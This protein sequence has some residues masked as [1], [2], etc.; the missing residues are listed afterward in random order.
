M[1]INFTQEYEELRQQFVEKRQ[2]RDE[3]KKVIDQAKKQNA[4][5]VKKKTEAATKVQQHAE[6]SR[7]LV[8]R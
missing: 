7:Q 5:L 6:E 2:K 8:M 1:T 3:L 4:P